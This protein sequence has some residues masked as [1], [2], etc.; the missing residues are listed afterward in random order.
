MMKILQGLKRT[1][2][3]G[4]SLIEILVAM[5][6]LT[7]IVLIVSVIFQQTSIAWSIGLQR[8][9]SQSATRAVVGAISRDL[10]M[11]VDPSMFVISPSKNGESL[12]EE[13]IDYGVSV[14]QSM[15]TAMDGSR[16]SFWI[17]RPDNTAATAIS[18]SD[19]SARELA[20][21]EYTLGSRVTRK[22]TVFNN[23]GDGFTTS[24][25]EQKTTAFD[26]GQGGISAE[27]IQISND[28][29][30][31]SSSYPT[32]GIKLTVRPDRPADIDDYE[33]YV[34]SCGPDREWDT[35]DDIRPWVKGEEN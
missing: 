10:A 8:A 18:R 27:E 35:D 2:R 33:I 26:L 31:Y 9:D 6:I 34:G 5:T 11:I 16:L 21:V 22:E 13:A 30:A 32:A 3:K 12:Q 23:T 1:S 14:G 28:S 7:I 15:D 19:V 25:N 20:Y 17:V 29:D 24:T 4:F